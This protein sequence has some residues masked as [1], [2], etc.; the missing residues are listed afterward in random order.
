MFFAST[1]QWLQ[2]NAGVDPAKVVVAGMSAGAMM[3]NRV[4]CDAADAFA[5]V[6]AVE[7][8]LMDDSKCEP[9][10]SKQLPWLGFC[11]SPSVLQ[12]ARCRVLALPR[13]RPCESVAPT[14]SPLVPLTAGGHGRPPKGLASRKLL[15]RLMHRARSHAGVCIAPSTLTVRCLSAGFGSRRLARFRLPCNGHHVQE[16]DAGLG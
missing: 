1:A 3:A 7:G 10:P 8:D 4:G 12:P 5:A 13:D 2:P 11:T 15:L 16:H 14:V 9:R 6:A